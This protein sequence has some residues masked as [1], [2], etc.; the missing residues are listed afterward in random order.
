[1]KLNLTS[2]QPEVKQNGSLYIII[3]ILVIIILILIFMFIIYIQCK[4]KQPSIKLK[5]DNN[6]SL[7]RFKTKKKYT[8][9]IHSNGSSESHLSAETSTLKS[10][11]SHR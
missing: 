9:D 8:E 5:L 11:E 3:G 6:E 10:E 4:K 1:M 7:S 2:D